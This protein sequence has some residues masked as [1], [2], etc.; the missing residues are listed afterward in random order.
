MNLTEIA[1]N[2]GFF[3]QSHFNK[4]LKLFTGKSPKTFFERK[5]IW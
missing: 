5:Q 3:D 2:N 1:H 4:E